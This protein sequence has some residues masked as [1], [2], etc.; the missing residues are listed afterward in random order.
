MSLNLIAPR[1]FMIKIAIIFFV[2][3]HLMNTLQVRATDHTL[4]TTGLRCPEPV[5]MLRK[6]IREIKS[7]ETLLIIADDPS[8]SRDIPSFCRFMEHTLLEQNTSAQPLLY[9]V[10]KN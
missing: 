4:D 1:L 3:E 6:K 5:M 8:T 9:V 10:E 7:G 2:Y